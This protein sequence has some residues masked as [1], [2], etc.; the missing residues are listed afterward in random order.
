MSKPTLYSIIDVETTGGDPKSERITEIAIIL[1]DGEKVLDEFS[2]LINPEIAI[3][4]FITRITGIDNSLVRDAPKFYE[5]ARQV[6]EITEGAIF[7]A[8]NSRFDYSFVQKEFRRLGYTFSRKQLCTV[9]LSRKLMPGLPSYSLGNLCRHLSITNDQ[10]HR[11]MSDTKATVELFEHLLSISQNP[12]HP[13]T[14][15]QELQASRLP[16][17]LSRQKVDDLPETVGVYYFHDEKGKILY[18]GKS[19]NVRK[20]VLSHFSSAHRA[21]RTMEMVDQIYDLSVVETGSELL[22]LLHENEEI[23][24]IQ[25]PYNRA[26][27]RRSFKIGVYQ[28]ET[29][30][31][32]LRLYLDKYHEDLL[33]LA[34]FSGRSQADAALTR[35]GR[36]FGLCPKLYGAEQGP[37]RCFHHQLHICQGACVGEEEPEAYNERVKKT[38]SALSYGRDRLDSFLIVGEGR[39]EDEKSVVFVQNGSYRGHG[40]LGLDVLDF[41]PEEIAAAVPRKQEAPDVQRIIQGYVKKHPK[42]IL[43]LM[44]RFP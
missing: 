42:E 3:P 24:R 8:H 5:V 13:H 32:Y 16:P 27:R 25:P 14:L 38:I 41:P 12:D 30:A 10:A 1:H 23:K 37:G 28:E 20:R 33:P 19:T 17:N 7:V 43:P 44:R 40:Y 36:H 4:D 22:A 26:Q 39:S 21:R 6:V 2:S 9:K 11:A 18:V 31:G 34:G 29:K 15:T 35:W